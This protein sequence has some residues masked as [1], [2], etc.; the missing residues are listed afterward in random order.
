MKKR[1]FHLTYEIDID[2]E[3]VEQAIRDA[4]TLV[5]DA[6]YAATWN[7]S[8]FESDIGERLPEITG[9][10]TLAPDGTVDDCTALIEEDD[11]IDEND[12]EQQEA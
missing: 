12:E 10:A 5:R 2:A 4:T 8:S 7:V 6:S 1:H 3:T 11:E 9:W